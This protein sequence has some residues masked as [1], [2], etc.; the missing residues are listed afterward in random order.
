LMIW[1]WN[2]KLAPISIRNTSIQKLVQH[3]LQFSSVTKTIP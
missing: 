3:F 2:S 1:I